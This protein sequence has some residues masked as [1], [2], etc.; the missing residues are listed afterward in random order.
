[1]SDKIVTE[2]EVTELTE[3]AVETVAEEPESATP[4]GDNGEIDS[5]SIEYEEIIKDYLD[6]G[7]M[8]GI[9]II[10]SSELSNE[11]IEEVPVSDEEMGK[12]IETFSDIAQNQ[13]I[14]GRVIGQNEKE[15][16]MDIGFK[17]EGIIPRSEFSGAEPPNL[18]DSIE[19]YLEKIE[20]KNGQTILSKEKA[21]WMKGWLK[22]MQIHKEEGTVNGTITRRIKGG[23]V[24]DVDGIQAFLPGSQIDVR[25]V[26]DF[27]NFLGKEMEFKV[28]KINQLRKNVVLSR[29]ALLYNTMKDQRESLFEEIEVGQIVEGVVKN[30]TDFGVFVDLGGMDGLLHITDLSWGRVN[31][32]SE[33]TKVGETISVKIIDIDKDKLRISLGLKQLTPHPWENVEEKFPV[34]TKIS[35]KVVS[36]TNYG[37]FV[38]LET[39]VEGLV[40]ISEMSWS[41]GVHRPDEVVQLG[42]EVEAKILSID[43][44]ERKIAL[45][46]KQLLPDPWENVDEQYAVGSTLKGIVRNLTQFGAFVEL[47][48]G[49]DGLIHVSDLSWTKVVRH[50]KEILRKGEE[51]EAKVLEVSQENHRIALGLKQASED[52]WDD[53]I[54]HFSVGKIVG[55]T[56]IR[57]LDKGI[58]VELEMDVEGIVPADSQSEDERDPSLK[59][60][61]EIQ[62]EV[63]EVKPEDKKV[64]LTFVDVPTP[65][66]APAEEE[67][68]ET[69]QEKPEVEA[70]SEDQKSNNE[71]NDAEE[72]ESTE[73]IDPEETE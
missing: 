67:A 13:I 42:Q 36:L 72:S 9:R 4:D 27:D 44:E 1:M 70:A 35:G 45:G 2:E 25:P 51:V 31:H 20:D 11:D 7:L 49:V 12:Y 32:P 55:G 56:I 10:E 16:I 46:F 14:T 19:V 21:V 71:P 43:T 38:E 66:E 64:M 34:G 39:G 69:K 53:I 40:H 28:V 62:C 22:L 50:P 63:V 57:T 6:P 8:N 68:S 60:G 15:I 59:E 61:Q 54:T 23:L 5:T 48:E 33:V 29:K 65:A 41:R 47:E 52:P 18:G 26:Q 3:D 30:I 24:V 73:E 58:I 17:S 37:A